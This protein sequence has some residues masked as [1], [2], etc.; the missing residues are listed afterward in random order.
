MI[1]IC[2]DRVVTH[3][4]RHM[5][6][7]VRYVDVAIYKDCQKTYLCVRRAYFTAKICTESLPIFHP[8][9]QSTLELTWVG[10]GEV[11]TSMITLVIFPTEGV[12]KFHPIGILHAPST[13]NHHMTFST[14]YIG[15]Y[16]MIKISDV[17]NCFSTVGLPMLYIYIYIYIIFHHHWSAGAIT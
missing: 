9:I 7:I 4:Y 6:R 2:V 15:T 14:T 3:I 8:S 16:C 11:D 10:T 5:R 13:P 1:I 17:H 12:T